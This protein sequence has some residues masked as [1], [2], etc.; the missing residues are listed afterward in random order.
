MHRQKHH[1]LCYGS[2]YCVIKESENKRDF[3]QRKQK[4]VLAF[5]FIYSSILKK[6]FFEPSKVMYTGGFYQI[7]VLNNSVV[8]RTRTLTPSYRRP[9]VLRDST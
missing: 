1:T 4:S 7:W 3:L 8:H 9:I 2:D 6:I 5:F